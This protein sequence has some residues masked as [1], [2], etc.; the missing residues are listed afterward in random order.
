MLRLLRHP[1][2]VDLKEAFKRKQRVYLVFE[3]IDKNL[4]EILES[5]PNGLDG[6]RIRLFIFQIIKAL[7]FCHSNDIIHRDIKPEN[8]LVSKKNE[9]KLCDFGF[10]RPSQ[11]SK[12]HITDYVATRWYRSPEILLNCPQYG[13]PADLWAVAC[14]LGE[15]IDGQPLFPGDN[16]MD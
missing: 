5:E 9:L 11:K 13:K 15:L 16:E 12:E 3:F 8:L 14:I 4:L 1:N 6:E 7:D 2:I 10:A